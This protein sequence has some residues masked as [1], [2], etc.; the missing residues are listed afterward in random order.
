MV[1]RKYYPCVDGE[2]AVLG[3]RFVVLMTNVIFTLVIRWP[4]GRH[5]KATR[6]SWCWCWTED[7]NSGC[8]YYKPIP[9]WPWIRTC[10]RWSE[11]NV[12]GYGRPAWKPLRGRH[13][14]TVATAFSLV[15]RRRR[16]PGRWRPGRIVGS[17]L[18]PHDQ[19]FNDWQLAVYLSLGFPD[20]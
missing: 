1:L 13:S 4:S 10:S 12:R 18:C 2:T 8:N 7:S 5:D 11:R 14:I 3:C 15:L 19:G 20:Q 9:A 17:S 6:S 16:L